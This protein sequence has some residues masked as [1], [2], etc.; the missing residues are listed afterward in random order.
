MKNHLD[1][2]SSI[3][4]NSLVVLF[5]FLNPLVHLYFIRRVLI[6]ARSQFLLERGKDDAQFLLEE[7]FIHCLFIVARSQ[8]LLGGRDGARYNIE[9]TKLLSTFSDFRFVFQL[10][11]SMDGM[12][13]GGRGGG[14][15]LVIEAW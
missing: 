4:W 8:F 7:T 1:L 12:V 14:S 9:W 11:L 3:S 6:A 15:I 10:S 2:Y 13:F 5:D